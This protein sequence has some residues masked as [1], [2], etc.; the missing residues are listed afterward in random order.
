MVIQSMTGFGRGEAT[1][2]GMIAVVEI[3][4]VN[5]RYKEARF[6][7]PNHHGGLEMELREQLFDKFKRGSFDIWGN[8]KISSDSS[9]S[10]PLDHKKIDTFLAVAKQIAHQQ[11]LTLEIRPSD[12]LRQEFYQETSNDLLVTEANLLRDSFKKA[13]RVLEEGRS[14]EG[15]KLKVIM[16]NHLVEYTK[17]F[18][19]IEQQADSFRP[20]IEERLRNRFKEFS[21]ELTTI[22]TPRF[23]QEVVYYLEKLDISEEINRIHSHL[24]KMQTLLSKGDEAGRQIDFLVQELNRETNTIGSKSG[25]I[26][27]SD[28]VIGMKGQ[29]EKI[30]E[31]GLN[32]E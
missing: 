6:R 23:L 32:I 17:E 25:E 1:C 27:I 8:I 14:K 30:R 11:K 10:I 22:D 16:Q 9:A 31:Q 24:K 3:K 29:L 21:K 2:P 13:V 26:L 12:F 28:H 20:K 7:L 18:Q 19:A 15:E 5:H 4:S